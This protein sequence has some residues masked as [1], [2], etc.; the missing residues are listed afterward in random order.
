MVKIGRFYIE[1]FTTDESLH[2]HED[3][4]LYISDEGGLR[5]ESGKG[6]CSA[7]YLNPHII[8]YKVW[9]DEKN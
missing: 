9:A 7:V 3:V 4:T 5:I 1:V 2:I 8:Y 6:K